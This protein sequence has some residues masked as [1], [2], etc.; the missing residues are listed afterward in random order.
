MTTFD[1]TSPVGARKWP[2]F[3]FGQG[4]TPPLGARKLPF[5]GQVAPVFYRTQ[6]NGWIFGFLQ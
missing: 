2:F 5:S 1:L 6:G 4:L 3:E